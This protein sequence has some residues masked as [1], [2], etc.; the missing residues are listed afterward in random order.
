MELPRVYLKRI[1][2]ISSSRATYEQE[3]GGSWQLHQH[4]CYK[5][6]RS[7]STHQYMSFK[8]AINDMD[9]WRVPIHGQR[10]ENRHHLLEFVNLPGYKFSYRNRDEKRDGGVGA[11]IKDC[12]TYKIR[13]DIISLDDSL[14]HLWVKAKGKNQKS[15]YLIGIVYQP[16]S[17]NATK[18]EW[19]EKIDAVLSSIIRTWDNTIIL[20][21]DT[22]NDLLSSS[23]ILDIYEQMLHTNQL[24]YHINVKT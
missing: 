19:I 5:N 11:H 18:I 2:P 23:T 8:Y 6:S 7:Q 21:G 1:T 22:N 10:I 17:E 24:S 14:E 16:R 20:T 3:R 13:N 15:P 9:F 4:T 12:V